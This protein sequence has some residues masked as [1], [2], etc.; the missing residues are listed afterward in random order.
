MGGGENHPRNFALQ[1]SEDGIKYTDL[2]VHENDKS[3]KKI[4]NGSWDIDSKGQ[5]RFL[6][7]QNQG[8]PKHLCCSGIEFYGTLLEKSGQTHEFKWVRKCTKPQEKHTSFMYF[9]AEEI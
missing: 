9:V 7:I 2:K 6:R 3:V 5:W 8:A 4:Q 1:G